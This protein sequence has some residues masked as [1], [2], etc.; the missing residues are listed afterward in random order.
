MKSKISVF[1]IV[2]FVVSLCTLTTLAQTEKQKE[3]LFLVDEYAVN[4]SMV[5]E[6]EAVMKEWVA[7]CSKHKFPYSWMTYSGNDFHYILVWPLENYADI[8]KMY[9]VYDEIEKKVGE[10]QW[11]SLSKRVVKSYEYWHS[12]MYYLIPERS[13]TPEN[14]RLKPE[15]I[16]YLR[17]GFYYLIPG[18]G[19][20]FAENDKEWI[21][22][23]KQ[24]NIPDG[25]QIY[26]GDNGTD[27]PVVVLVTWGENAADYFTQGAKNEKI[28]GEEAKALSK[29]EQALLRKYE[30]RTGRPRPDLSYKS[31]E[32]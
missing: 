6:F 12:S 23:H 22:L 8:D 15:E 32:K 14:P 10:K 1:L 2:G 29:K 17:W 20:A 4:P 31:E 26:V 13:Y 7:L 9:K 19:K 5:D 27:M 28:L 16:N 11:Q 30:S 3:Q 24:K 25:Y 21:A 18:K